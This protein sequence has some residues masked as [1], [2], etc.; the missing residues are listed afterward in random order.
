MSRLFIPPKEELCLK[1][2]GFNELS[3]NEYKNTALKTSAPLYQQA[4]DFFRKEYGL[5]HDIDD[6]D[7][8]TKFYYRIKSYSDR[9]NNYHDI[10]LLLR[11]RKDWA[12][13]EFKTYHEAEY[14]CLVKLIEIVKSKI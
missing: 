5:K 7:I 13:I 11:K 6:D 10:L 12:E 8:G 2:L 3:F 1:E 14:A 9:F 4:F